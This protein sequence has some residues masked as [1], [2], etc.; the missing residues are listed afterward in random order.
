MAITG[1]QPATGGKVVVSTRP[2]SISELL[3]QAWADIKSAVD[4]HNIQITPQ[5][6]DLKASY[7]PNPNGASGGASAALELDV[8][9][10][11]PLPGGASGTL[12]G[13]LELDPSVDFTYQGGL[14][15][16][17]MRHPWC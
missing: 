2:A 8:N 12:S 14:M 3:G 4:P 11:V 5:L 1:V 7:V 9:D 10:S 17:S 16:T 6:R 15:P 13:S